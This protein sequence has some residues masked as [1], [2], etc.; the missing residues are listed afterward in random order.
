MGEPHEFPS[1]WGEDFTN[2][3]R[4][5]EG[6]SKA[7]D[8]LEEIYNS[9]PKGGKASQIAYDK[10]QEALKK[11]TVSSIDSLTEVA[12]GLNMDEHYTEDEIRDMI[13]EINLSAS[14][15]DMSQQ[16]NISQKNEAVFADFKSRLKSECMK[17]DKM[18]EPYLKRIFSDFEPDQLD[19]HTDANGTRTSINWTEKTIEAMKELVEKGTEEIPKDMMS[20]K[21]IASL[22][23]K[24]AVM[25]GLG[26]GAYELYDMITTAVCNIAVSE[27]G[28]FVISKDG[29]A[30]PQKVA[31]KPD[32]PIPC[33][34][35]DNCCG[36]CKK[37]YLQ[38][39]CSGQKCCTQGMD[40]QASAHPLT[41]WTYTYVCKSPTGV[42]LDGFKELGNFLAGLKGPLE[43]F[44]IVVGA[45]VAL[46]IVFY[47]A[48]AL[49]NFYEY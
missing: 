35:Y 6:L 2:N 3:M 23:L 10:W 21:D 34:S 4:D 26:I 33:Q 31:I 17:A 8:R 27:S 5:Y 44:A 46:F 49:Y 43:T 30:D 22:V 41:E 37:G 13:S 12:K 32:Y 25:I 16:T 48:K 14:W 18:L 38:E 47:I 45:I 1:A 29:S 9:S 15:D 39:P 20:K 36:G 19:Y 28:C 11:V 7:A 42:V 24:F 40:A